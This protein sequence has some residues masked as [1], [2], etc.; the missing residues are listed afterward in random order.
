MSSY[1][2]VPTGTRSDD[3][4]TESSMKNAYCYGQCDSGISDVFYSSPME[5]EL[6]G[7]PTSNNHSRP[8][9]MVQGSLEDVE[10]EDSG[11]MMMGEDA[12]KDSA[13]SS[14]TESF[15]PMDV[16]SRTRSNS[17]KSMSDS[18][19]F[20]MV[21]SDHQE[22]RVSSSRSKR[23]PRL[24]KKSMQSSVSTTV[25]NTR[26][27]VSSRIVGRSASANTLSST[28]ELDRSTT[29]TTSQ[30]RHQKL[31]IASSSSTNALAYMY[32]AA[33]TTTDNQRVPPLPSV[34]IQHLRQYM[35]LFIPDKEGDT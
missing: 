9:L 8:K 34:G 20:K 32:T 22:S 26:P 24:P 33:A 3:Y 5:A 15:T 25:S 7:P 1:S 17:P 2:K 28:P 11:I 14:Q 13:R 6:D 16:D 21:M 18:E 10:N 29:T 23:H 30:Q 19:T 4:Y 31:S 35:S 27:S 12:Q